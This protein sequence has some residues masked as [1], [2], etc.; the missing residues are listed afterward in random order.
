MSTKRVN[1]LDNQQWGRLV[2]PLLL[3]LLCTAGSVQARGTYQ[4]AEA[5]IKEAFAGEIPATQRIWL[6]G[7]LGETYREVMQEQPP[8]LRL[9][10]W[11]Q[12]ERTVWILQ[13]TGKEHPI[14]AGFIVAGGRLQQARVLEFRESRGWE[15]RYPFFTQQF[16]HLG[17]GAGQQL[18]REIDGITGATLSV[19]AM[20]RMARLALI[21]S[22][23]VETS[24]DTP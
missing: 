19:H 20:S 5:F 24:H 3:A 1:R 9:R 10:Y 4:T 22:D 6:S 7:E 16:R 11:R 15:I 8:Q 23:K 14:T 17:L 18:E 13:A 21:L 12:R 2:R